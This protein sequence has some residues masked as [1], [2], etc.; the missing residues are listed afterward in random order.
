[1][2]SSN[3]YLHYGLL[4]TFAVLYLSTAFVSFYHAVEFFN[5]SNA[6]WLAVILSIVAEIGQATVLFSL[7]MS[8]DKSK[9]MPWFV[10]IVLTV[11]QVIGNVYSCYVY[12]EEANSPR[13]EYFQKSI[14]FFLGEETSV[15][16]MKVIVAWITGSLLP[17]IALCLTSLIASYLHN[18][19][20]TTEEAIDIIETTMSNITNMS[21]NTDETQHNNSIDDSDNS[22][23]LDD[24]PEPPLTGNEQK[25]IGDGIETQHKR[26]KKLDIIVPNTVENIEVK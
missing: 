17:I 23:I 11:L 13:F 22:N 18:S 25:P 3:K 5:L 14:L 4:S 12:I 20:D 26:K 21:D 10:M 2:D 9:I 7:L 6:I 8:K 15:G 1:M 16:D 19:D 24:I